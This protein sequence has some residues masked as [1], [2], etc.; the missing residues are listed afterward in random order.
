[1]AATSKAP[2]NEKSANQREK[3]L[4]KRERELAGKHN[5]DDYNTGDGFVVD[6][7]EDEPVG[8]RSCIL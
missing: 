2:S 8:R 6:S 4:E 3:E 1:V 5:L 7:E